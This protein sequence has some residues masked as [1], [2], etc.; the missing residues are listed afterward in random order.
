[1]YP[2]YWWRPWSFLEQAQWYMIIGLKQKTNVCWQSKTTCWKNIGLSLK[3]IST[4]LKPH[5]R[6][7]KRQT[8][9]YISEYSIWIN[10]GL[11]RRRP[12]SHGSR[13]FLQMHPVLKACWIFSKQ[14]LNCWRQNHREPTKL[15]EIRF[16][17]PKNNLRS[18]SPYLRFNLL[19]IHNWVCWYRDME[20]V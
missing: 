1:M 15:S 2:V 10:L 5:W 20:N 4:K 9:I 12:P 7:W 17:S 3:K 18:F 16:K 6:I 19:V 13:R 14:N 8:G 11:R